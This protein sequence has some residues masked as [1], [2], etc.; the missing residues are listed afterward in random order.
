M[1]KNYKSK[2]K[3]ITQSKGKNLNLHK[4]TKKRSR[5]MKGGAPGNNIPGYVPLPGS[6]MMPQAQNNLSG[7]AGQVPTGPPQP[8]AMSIN[9][10]A[11]TNTSNNT[12]INNTQMNSLIT[13]TQMNSLINN[14]QMNSPTNTSIN[15]PNNTPTNT[16]TNTSTNTPTNTSDNNNKNNKNK[17]KN[18]NKDGT[19]TYYEKL[20]LA[21][22][23]NI[24]LS[25]GYYLVGV[26]IGSFFSYVKQN[27]GEVAKM[28][29]VSEEDLKTV[30]QFGEY[31]DQDFNKVV[32]DEVGMRNED[33][34]RP[35]FPE[36]HLSEESSLNNI[37]KESK[38]YSKTGK[39]T[40]AGLLKMVKILS[41]YKRTEFQWMRIA[42][43]LE[44]LYLDRN[45]GYIP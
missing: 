25:E 32:S 24:R 40:P 5:K 12:L 26:D 7:N 11:L 28:E 44:T 19:L 3:K 17:N 4:N 20:P 10:G 38:K 18:K 27:F 45:Q 30:N 22:K 43:Y 37:R 6:E 9:S 15:T 36:N 8:P 2:S 33:L 23:F 1:S 39:I 35:L 13:N 42:S 16:P 34:D 29:D 41:K 21:E 14:T 31:V